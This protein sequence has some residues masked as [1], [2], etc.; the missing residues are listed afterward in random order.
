MVI[1][2]FSLALLLSP[3]RFA[4]WLFSLSGLLLLGV[5]ACGDNTSF[6]ET[7][8]VIIG[9][10]SDYV[11]PAQLD[12][13]DVVMVVDGTETTH[14]QLVLGS[15]AGTTHF[16]AEFAFSDVSPG[17]ALAFTIKGYSSHDRLV[18]ARHLT[19]K[20]RFHDKRL[21]RVHLEQ[22]CSLDGGLG[23]EVPAPTCNETT[24]TC[25]EGTCQNAAIGPDRHEA[26]TPDWVLT[27]SDACKPADAGAP[28]IIVGAGQSNYLAVEDYATAQVEA[29]P[30]GGHHIWI[31]AR[32]HNL[33]RSGSITEVGGEIPALGLSIAPLLVVHTLS[34]DNG[35]YCKIFGLRFQ[36]D[37]GAD[38]QSMLGQQIEVTV[39]IEDKSGD[40]G[41]G[42][43]WFT[44]STD[45]I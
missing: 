23:G 38:V 6:P 13:L 9:V 19:T 11:V 15:G 43:R 2:F 27:G 24:H 8:T 44:L 4:R 39:K 22:Q 41:I 37:I 32:V 1:R 35:G 45:T 17:A 3:Q 31:A 14:Q 16:P 25:I 5:A 20:A 21:I 28:E 18:V 12:H 29:G 30:Q 34:I 40:I 26:Y 7:S 10:T 36:I 42:K 33:R